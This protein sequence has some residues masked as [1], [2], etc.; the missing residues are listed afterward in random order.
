[1]QKQIKDFFNNNNNETIYNLF[2]EESR[3]AIFILDMNSR[4]IKGNEA[5][6]RI[7][8]Y[9]IEELEKMELKDIMYTPDQLNI[10][11]LRIETSFDRGYTFGTQIY[12]LLTKSVRSFFCVF[13]DDSE[14]LILLRAN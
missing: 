11:K 6:E 1:M 5:V 14:F 10:A 3:D 7:L 4:F 9:S 12:K 13:I 8:E 2:F